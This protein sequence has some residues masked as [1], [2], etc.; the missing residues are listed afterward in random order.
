MSDLE[1]LLARL[2][3]RLGAITA[4]PTILDGGITNRNYRVGFAGRDYVVRLPGTDTSLLGISREAERTAAQRAAELGLGPR[5]VV[6]DDDCLVTEYVVAVPS[7]P[8]ALT[9]APETVARALRSFHDSGV[10]LSVRFWVPDLL[11]DYAA[12]VRAR[13]GTLPP[14]YAAAR[15]AS[16]AGSGRPV[17]ADRPRALSQRSPSGERAADRLTVASCSWIGSTR[18]WATASSTWATWP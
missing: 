13:G 15:E 5:V 1:G 9:A 2:E 17:A 8:E 4:G 7:D 18:G 14:Q 10:E 3:Q 16:P 12:V 11:D 6:G